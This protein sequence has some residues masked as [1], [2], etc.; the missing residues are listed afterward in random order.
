M[1]L[2]ESNQS[3]DSNIPKPT[4]VQ[5]AW[6]QAELG[7]LVSYDLH[8][9]DDKHYDQRRNR[10]TP[11]ADINIFNPTQLDTDQWARTIK[12]MGANFAILTASH[13]TGFRLWQSDVNPYSLKSVKWGDGKRDI[14]REFIASCKKYNI[15]P[16]VYLGTRWNSH[17]GVYDFKVTKRSSITQE[18]YN[19]MIEKEV[20]E[21]CSRYGDLF[22]L[23]FDGGAHG[24]K[25]GGP[26]VLSVFEKYQPNCLFYHNYQRADARWGG[27]ESGTVPYPCWAR[28][29]FEDGYEGHKKQSHANGFRLLKYGDPEGKYW[30]PAMSDAPL[31]SHEWFWD[32]GDDH[33]IKP[34][35]TLVNMY[36]NSVGRNSTLILGLT[37]DNRGFIPNA[38]VKRCQEFGRAIRN[39]FSNQIA[40]ASGRGNTIELTLPG[41]SSFDHVVI[42]ED[43]RDGERVRKFKLEYSSNERWTELNTGSC[44]GHKRII[45]MKP[46]TADRLRLTVSES[47]AEP[48]IK[49]LAVYNSLK[50]ETD[51][52]SKVS[53]AINSSEPISTR[54]LMMRS[55]PSI[56]V[57]VFG[58]TT[59][60]GSPASIHNE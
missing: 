11:C 1:G 10:V 27:S 22:E 39:I 15:K 14:V 30:C 34:L 35:K 18:S 13:E 21:I 17:L 40:N 31:R 4:A 41:K 33:K 6:Q 3:D 32:E 16:G 28:M 29:P 49:K 45:R 36:Y 55:S 25:D 57:G 20:Q 50:T 44:I 60:L 38:D 26:D 24:P 8:I 54:P 43:V 59:R 52:Q 23:W 51:D 12:E 7:V 58:S 47:V 46:V 5:L 48:I 19:A 2:A 9:F 42:Q 56:S 37:P 53:T